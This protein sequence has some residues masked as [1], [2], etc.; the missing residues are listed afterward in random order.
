[1]RFEFGILAGEIS[2]I[3]WIEIF[4]KSLM[5]DRAD[6]RAIDN[7]MSKLKMNFSLSD[8]SSMVNDLIVQVYKLL[9]K[10]GMQSYVE[11]EDPRRIVNWTIRALEP[12]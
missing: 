9:K 11:T 6:P 2:E 8:S 1:M 3:K 5:A 10:Y 7:A 12:A 4:R